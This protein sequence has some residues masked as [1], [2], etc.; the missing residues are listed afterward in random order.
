MGASTALGR[1]TGFR[2][3]LVL[4]LT[5]ALT[6]GAALAL[7]PVTAQADASQVTD[8][9]VL[10]TASSAEPLAEAAALPRS[11]RLSRL[12]AT[13]P[14]D[15]DQLSLLSDAA[16]FGLTVDSVTPWSAVV[17]G[18]AAAVQRLASRAEVS[19]V[20]PSGGPAPV[21]A[22]PA[23]P[24]WGYQLR[25]AYQAS[26]AKPVGSITPVIATIQFS[27]WDSSQL[28]GYVTN[29]NVSLPTQLP[30]LPAG[31]FT[32]ISVDGAST[33]D[34]GVAGGGTEVALDQES[35][36]ATYPYA[37]QRAYFAPG[38][39]AGLVAALN[40]VAADAVRM[41]ALVAL[42]VSWTFCETSFVGGLSQQ[43]DD[44]HQAVANV[45]AAGVTVF[46]ASGDSGTSCNHSPVVGAN[47]PASDP[48]VLAVGGT[49]L[50]LNPPSETA[51]A[52]SGGGTSAYFPKGAATK[53]ALPD[54]AADADPNTGFP[55]WQG[56][57]GWGV[58]GGTSLASPVS[59]ASYAAELG[60]RGALNGGLGDLHNAL[61]S[62]PVSEFRDII[63]GSN[64]TSS[65]GPGYDQ[66]TGWGAPLWNQIVTRL[67]T[68]PVIQVPATSTSLVVPVAVT[69]PA[70]QAFLGW[71]TGSGTPPACTT[72]AGK[73]PTPQPVT[74][75]ADGTYRIWAEGY[76][77]FTRCFIVSTTTVV[78]G[79]TTPAPPATTTPA[80]VTS[81]APVTTAP[82]V[83]V[84]PAPVHTTLP[85]LPVSSP[86][87]PPLTQAPPG[88]APPAR[89]TITSD[90]T[91][92]AVT[93][94]AKQTSLG[95][96]ALF[97]AWDATDATGSGVRSVSATVFRDGKPVW[98]ASVASD[99]TLHLNGVAGHA[100]RL[101]IV[102]ADVAGNVAGF[103]STV[104][105]LPYDDR[106]FAL[107]KGWHRAT[108]HHA[109][110]GS[111]VRSAVQ[112]ATGSVTLTG[113]SYTLITSTGPAN[114][115]VAV[116]VDGR[117]VR[118]VSLY[119][120]AT[121][122]FVQVRLATFA[123]PGKH[124]ITLVVR[125]SKVGHA[126]GTTVVIDGLLAV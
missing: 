39:A 37:K 17:H 110:G 109:F 29:A 79:H 14:S 47:Y 3:V 2:R 41:P 91:P 107:G 32:A 93:L 59:A 84:T 4:P 74:V 54:I 33:T 24:L 11:A 87:D 19:S 6:G 99:S 18:S 22:D 10:R 20:L 102:A 104:V 88:I 42:S 96:T 100:Y 75:P 66:V 120:K 61:R 82:P 5:L 67:L 23:G 73:R 86:T 69:A 8:T 126:K 68:Q 114:G 119:S 12:Q 97:Y 48:L 36:Y 115:L 60:S 35:L 55:I 108:S 53:R 52:G 121:R 95:T 7:V 124:R 98:T 83:T 111:Y 44:L 15:T 50:T 122:T 85:V 76:V 21:A 1:S 57:S 117:H 64:G 30:A 81:S 49:S 56:A 106:S 51:W 89:A 38:D 26:A 72:S 45:V 112:G 34:G 90:V 16:A 105:H 116:Y 13:V 103:T 80:P 113:S 101:G 77:G 63:S 70:G 123:K 40:M 25:G 65:A 43:L 31:E 92:P 27:G 62:A 46:A 125:G 9:V 58:T 94:S 118:D 71:A 28:G 78:T